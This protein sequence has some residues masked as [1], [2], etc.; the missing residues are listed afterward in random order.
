M[1]QQYKNRAKKGQTT[2]TVC[3]PETN[4]KST[5]LNEIVETVDPLGHTGRS[6]SCPVKLMSLEVEDHRLRNEYD[7]LFTC[8]KTIAKPIAKQEPPFAVKETESPRD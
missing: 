1:L 3:C 6:I 8:R 4:S 5:I 7:N 2:K